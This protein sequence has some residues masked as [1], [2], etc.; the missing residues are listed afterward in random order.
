VGD[1]QHR[2]AQV[3]LEAQELV[4]QTA[5]DHRVHRPERLVHQEHGRVGGEGTGNANA[6]ALTTR[7]LVGIAVGELGRV[8]PDE[9]HQLL[10]AR[11]GGRLA[12]AVQQGHGHHVGQHHLV[13]EQPD[14]LDDVADAATQLHRVGVGDIDAV[15]VDP[16]GRRL[17]QPVD[18]L[19]RGRL[20]AA[21]RPHQADHCA[22]WDV[23]VELLHRHCAVGVGLAHALEPDHARCGRVGHATVW[24]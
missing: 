9:V 20:A 6:L 8:Q 4:L 24:L 15:E 2:L 1:H 11:L 10:G 21:R 7:E 23:E 14:L 19:Q 12:L 13:G 3:A 5:T 18:H 16:P 22:T 17:D